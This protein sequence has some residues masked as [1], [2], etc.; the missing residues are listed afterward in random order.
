MWF[1]MMA[2]AATLA[3]LALARFTS[4]PWPS[5]V[6][7]G[8][9]A[10]RS[11]PRRPAYRTCE[12]TYHQDR[13]VFFENVPA[14]GPGAVVIAGD[15][16]VEAGPWSELFGGLVYNRGIAGDDLDGLLGR[17]DAVV[18]AGPARLFLWIGAEDVHQGCP[19]AVVAD[20]YAALLARVRALSPATDLVLV[21]LP[22][23][24]AS[25]AESPRKNVVV[26][27]TN[28]KLRQL[29]AE[30]GAA[31]AD[32]HGLLAG[33]DGALESGYSFDGERLWLSAYPHVAA[34]LQPFGASLERVQ[35]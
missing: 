13:L 12:T 7:H 3:V 11:S 32:V 27:E 22:P 5:F 14:P 8:L 30:F 2:F 21:A 24:G 29:A 31:Y 6:R 25:V 1:V 23:F 26:V 17:L 19:A 28:T 16:H 34:V 10:E 9:P 20:R 33:D 35:V 15:A 4:R 18:S